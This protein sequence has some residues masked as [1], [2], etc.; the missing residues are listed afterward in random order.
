[1]PFRD[2]YEIADEGTSFALIAELYCR[3]IIEPDLI[4]N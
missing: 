4:L 3:D 2:A 1:M